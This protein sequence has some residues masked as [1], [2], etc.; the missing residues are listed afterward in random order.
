[1]VKFKM[2]KRHQSINDTQENAATSCLSSKTGSDNILGFAIVFHIPRNPLPVKTVQL[3]QLQAGKCFEGTDYFSICRHYKRF[4][5]SENCRPS[6]FACYTGSDDIIPPIK[7]SCSVGKM[8][9][10]LF[11]QS[12]LFYFFKAYFFT[13]SKHTIY[14]YHTIHFIYHCI[15]FIYHS[16]YFFFTAYIFS[17]QH[18]FYISYHTF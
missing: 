18:T 1:M 2:W 13:F 8:K 16:I 3:N 5:L 14:F 15:H 12:I 4:W 10:S 9:N 6:C 7:V 17:S 11:F